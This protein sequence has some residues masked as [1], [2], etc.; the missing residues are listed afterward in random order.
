MSVCMSVFVSGCLCASMYVNTYVCM[1]V[2]MYVNIY[3]CI[4]IICMPKHVVDMF[5]YSQD[6]LSTFAPRLKSTNSMDNLNSLKEE[7]TESVPQPETLV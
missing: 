3:T 7:L 4:Y 5:I 2:C 1:Y 6:G